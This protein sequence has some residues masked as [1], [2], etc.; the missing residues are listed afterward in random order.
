MVNYYLELELNSALST[1][2]LD[3]ALKK[4]S[5]KWHQRV[6]APSLEAR[7]E[8]E[9]K[10][11]MINEARSILLDE[12]KRAQYDDQ[13]V[14]T[15]EETKQEEAEKREVVLDEET[16]AEQLRIL[17][18]NEENV[19]IIK[20]INLAYSTGIR[21]GEF[22]WAAG[23][24]W[25]EVDDLNQAVVWFKRSIELDPDNYRSYTSLAFIAEWQEDYAGL[26]QYLDWLVENH[27]DDNSWIAGMRMKCYMKMGQEP[28]AYSV[29]QQYMKKNPKDIKFK[30]D[31]QGLYFDLIAE[32][33][34]ESTSIEKPEYVAQ[35]LEYARR[36]D[37]LYPCGRSREKVE[38]IEREYK[39]L[40]RKDTAK[41]GGIFSRFF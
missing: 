40:S 22:C 4:L 31:A 12:Q 30:Q 8:A 9:R 28:M 1:A 24:A 26:K 14:R 33:T 27:H 13:L 32:M 41:K 36:A 15:T 20:L 6:N 39:K 29:I 7:Q 25:I 10:V 37:E 5:M 19:E 21:N 3:Q 35:M 11:Q 2:E 16:V 17:Q 38:I 23:Q 34:Q 18:A